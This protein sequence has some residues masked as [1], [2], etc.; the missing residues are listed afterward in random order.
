M[1]DSVSS[2]SEIPN[3]INTEAVLSYWQ[4]FNLDG[5]RTEWNIISNEMRDYKSA[6]INGRKRLNEMTKAFRARPK[7]EQL[8]TVSEL[9]KAYQEEIDQL[10]KRSRFTETSFTS[11]YKDLYDAP[12]PVPYMES[13]SNTISNGT[14]HSLEIERLKSEIRQ[15][16]EEFQ[17]LKNQDITIR[18]LEDQLQEYKDN[19]EEKIVEEAERRVRIVREQC[20]QQLAESRDLQRSS[21]R[22]MQQAMDTAK[23]A[24]QSVDRIQSQLFEE[25]QRME[26]RIS[27]MALEQSTLL[28][29]NQ[30]L[31]LRIAELENE[32]TNLL[33]AGTVSPAPT[34]SITGGSAQWQVQREALE[35]LLQQQ[36]DQ[37]RA[38]EDQAR[39][40]RVKHDSF[41][42]DL[43][44]S[45]ARER[46]HVQ[47]L[48]VE[49]SRAVTRNQ[50]NALR[51]EVRTLRR[52]AFHTEEE[53]EFDDE[54]DD[55]VVDN[56]DAA[57]D[58]FD[59]MVDRIVDDDRDDDIDRSHR[60]IHPD[61]TDD[62]MT[63]EK[64]TP[65]KTPLKRDKSTVLEKQQQKLQ[66]DKKR[67]SKSANTVEELLAKR[68]RLVEHE[69]AVSRSDI[70]EAKRL[71]SIAR[72]AADS[73]RA[74]LESTQLQLQR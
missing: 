3:Q 13:L 45:L 56:R 4:Q 53:D 61:G 64:T 68:L 17:Q 69:L 31:S 5:K 18:R 7:E 8:L 49:L 20:D 44:Q 12:N 26:S 51:R 28:D 36:Q 63:P 23:Q 71:E 42:R 55:D 46:D 67:K 52:I 25:H 10:S 70:A 16:D 74:N 39:Q 48:K 37:M 33:N 14:L 22:R 27:A 15:Y 1:E 73:L 38:M 43:Q 66:Q 32:K 50:Y 41:S 65:Y 47:R 30:R 19:L 57:G 24:Q 60:R 34:S 62:T 40:D 35:Q 58:E 59:N 54:I 29:Q 2:N 21:E 6:S 72:E 9:L 11:I